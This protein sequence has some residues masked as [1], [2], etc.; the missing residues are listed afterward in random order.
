MNIA[1]CD[2]S[3]VYID[4]IYGKLKV[5]LPSDTVYH[6]FDSGYSFFSAD[7]EPDYLFL[8]IQM[9]GMDG[10]ELKERLE[11]K[12]I[13]TKIIFMTNY[14][15]RMRE[16]FGNGVVGFLSKPVEMERLKK[17]V[18]KMLAEMNKK[19]FECTLGGKHRVIPLEDILFIE[20]EDKYTYI[21]TRGN[22]RFCIRKTLKEWGDELPKDS[23]CKIN[24]SY[25][26][27][28]DLCQE[29]M[30]RIHLPGNKVV[31]VSR[32][33]KDDLKKGYTKYLLARAGAGT[34]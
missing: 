14:D 11:A 25:I 26:I 34:W 28:F 27:H 13:K 5:F 17:I 16:A 10:I 6:F 31:E 18:D 2:D 15:D 12:K 7:I 22:E 4:D 33:Y 30:K 29:N 1:I 23:F 21:F 8:D 3:M 9:P 19:Y 20:A 24:R 32:V